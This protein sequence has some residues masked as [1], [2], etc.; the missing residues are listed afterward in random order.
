MLEAAFDDPPRHLG[1]PLD[2]D[3]GEAR[4]SIALLHLDPIDIGPALDADDPLGSE[5]ARPPGPDRYL[6]EPLDADDPGASP[7]VDQ[8]SVSIGPNL[9][10]DDPQGSDLDQAAVSPI[11]IGELLDAGAPRTR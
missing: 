9:D 10:A 11:E 5:P 4:E 2:A 7:M 3:G 6:G 8:D 1:E